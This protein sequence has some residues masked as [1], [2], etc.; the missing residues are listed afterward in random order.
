[1]SSKKSSEFERTIWIVIEITYHEYAN[2]HLQLL[3]LL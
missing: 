1:M 3:N 2:K